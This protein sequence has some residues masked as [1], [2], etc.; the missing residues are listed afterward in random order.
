MAVDVVVFILLALNYTYYHGSSQD[1]SSVV[2]SDHPQPGEL[3]PAEE[4]KVPLNLTALEST[5][6]AD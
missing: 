6:A 3:I 4:E 1:V 2:E 5:S